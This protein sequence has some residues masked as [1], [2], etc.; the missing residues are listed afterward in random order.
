MP[1]ALI[2]MPGCGKSTVGRQ[3]AKQ[4][5]WR[6]VDADSEVIR[7]IGMPIREFFDA[8]GE[9][10]F[11]EIEEQ[12]IATLCAQSRVVIATGGGVVTRPANRE[13]L[14]QHAT[15]VYLRSTV[16]E[17]WRRLRHDTRRPLLQVADPLR[18]LRDLFR[19]RDPLYRDTAHH[20]IDAG[21][22]SVPGLASR[23]LMQLEMA[24]VVD[25]FRSEQPG[26][27]GSG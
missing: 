23:V 22:G 4:L 2:G 9:G 6:F 3:L 14:R 1:I 18:R 26:E 17:L 5:G 19:D 7:E 27:A 11:R 20:V 16:E 12:V 10:R 8:H 21:R 24:G 13:Q 15:V 25:P